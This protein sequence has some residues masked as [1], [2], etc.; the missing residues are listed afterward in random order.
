[1]EVTDNELLATIGLQTVRLDACVKEI[2]RLTDENARLRE[3]LEPQLEDPAA[4]SKLAPSAE[5][6]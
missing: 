4:G 1:M 5:G 3:Q 2:A 6:G